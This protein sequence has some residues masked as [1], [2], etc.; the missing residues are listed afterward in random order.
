VFGIAVPP[1]LAGLS[2]H[3]WRVGPKIAS[4]RPS[5][6]TIRFWDLKR[7]RMHQGAKFRARVGDCDLSAAVAS[8]RILFVL[9]VLTILGMISPA[10]AQQTSPEAKLKALGIELPKAPAPVGNYVGG[11]R[12]GNLLFMAGNGPRK[13]DGTGFVTGKLGADLSVE[14]GYKAARLAGIVMLANIR[15]EIGSLDRVRRI[16]RVV[17]LVNATPDFKDHPKVV[18]GVSDLLVEVFGDKGRSA[19][20]APG[21]GSL[22]FQVPIIVESI[23]EVDSN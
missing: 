11:V 21:A 10:G 23:V 13:L 18:D 5:A 8:M 9:A 15:A 6:A 3:L 12:V 2:R 1:G 14:D 4:L 16:V 17:G 22:P 20:T 7:R 19:R